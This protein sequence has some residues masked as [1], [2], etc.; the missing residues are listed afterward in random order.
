MRP[1][2]R[3]SD[4]LETSHSS[5]GQCLV[6]SGSQ[7]GMSPTRWIEVQRRAPLSFLAFFLFS[8]LFSSP[9]FSFSSLPMSCYSL[10]NFHP[11]GLAGTSSAARTGRRQMGRCH[12]EEAAVLWR[13][14]FGPGGGR[15]S[16][17]GGRGPFRDGPGSYQ[18]R[19]RDC[20]LADGRAVL[21]MASRR[22]RQ[23]LLETLGR[24]G[25][26]PRVQCFGGD[27][28]LDPRRDRPATPRTLGST[29]SIHTGSGYLNGS[30]ETHSVHGRTKGKK[31]EQGKSRSGSRR[32]E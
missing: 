8:F 30:V 13:L 28:G 32:G 11:K 4:V 19:S 22:L 25:R 5:L 3:M 26:S 27:R 29:K 10:L 17:V 12:R 24:R 16:D 21:T 14:L 18:V 31:K 20:P 23:R 7:S 2:D 1:G 6:L 9:L 15:R